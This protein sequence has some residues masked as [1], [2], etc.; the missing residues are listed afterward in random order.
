MMKILNT[1]DVSKTIFALL[2]EKGPIKIHLQVQ[3]E[4]S[5]QAEALAKLSE[6][7]ESTSQQIEDTQAMLDAL[8]SEYL[9]I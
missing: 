5:V 9:S 1:L 8:Q 7:L 4:N 3:A 2:C 6:K